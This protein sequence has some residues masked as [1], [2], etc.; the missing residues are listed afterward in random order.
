MSK[1]LPRFLSFA[2]HLLTSFLETRERFGYVRNPAM[3][4]HLR[5][6][7][8]Y[9]VFRGIS[10]LE[11]IDTALIANWVFAIPS[12]SAVTKNNKLSVARSLSRYLVRIG[13]MKSNPAESIPYLRAK[14]RRPHIY[15]LQELGALIRQAQKWQR[16]PAH[17]FVGHVMEMLVRLLYACGLRLGEALRLKIDDIDFA[18]ETISIWKAKFHKERVLPFS[19][20]LR[21]SLERYL[22][23]RNKRYPLLDQQGAY[24]FRHRHG[25]Y[26][27]HAI[28]GSFK[29]L[30]T[31]CGLSS[32]NSGR[33]PRLHD[34]RHSF[35]VDRLYKWYQ[36]GHDPMAKLPLLSTYMGHVSVENTQVYLAATRALLREGN[37]RFREHSECI[38]QQF[39]R[40]ASKKHGNR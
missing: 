36:Q 16:R 34:L 20:S 28:E 17:R 19:K 33:S 12:H 9:L 7:D 23:V 35:A 32:V 21:Q 2:G 14:P 37:R 1:S 3:I 25:R 10:R 40:R 8:Y 38:P 5:H 27:Q 29:R 18:E 30:L 11:E 31:A 15:T 4:H 13:K 26:G 39:I 6:L 24:I 22:A